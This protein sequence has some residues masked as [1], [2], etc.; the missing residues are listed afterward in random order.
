MMDFKHWDGAAHRRFTGL[1]NG[2]V[3]ENYEYFCKTGRQ[4]HVRIP[5]I[6]GVNAED[7]AAFASYFA[8]QNT[9][10]CV[11]EFLPYHEYGKGKYEKQGKIYTVENGFVSSEDVRILATEIQN[12]NLKLIHT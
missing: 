12:K 7:P 3:K 9:Q 6:G 1:D 5:L 11:F 4:L 10:N 8:T 2:T